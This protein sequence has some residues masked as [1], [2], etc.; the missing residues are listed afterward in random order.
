M[1]PPP[2]KQISSMGIEKKKRAHQVKRGLCVY[3]G[4]RV[5]QVWDVCVL[6][7]HGRINL[8]MCEQLLKGEIT[9]LTQY[10]R[11]SPLTR[12]TR[13]SPL[14]QYTRSSPLTRY[15]RSSP[16]SLIILLTSKVL[17]TLFQMYSGVGLSHNASNMWGCCSVVHS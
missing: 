8:Q 16:V 6:W 5:E 13:S 11:S 4:I 2:I 17:E 9:Q 3:C 14:T 12:Y 1:T 7:D 15:T 10:T